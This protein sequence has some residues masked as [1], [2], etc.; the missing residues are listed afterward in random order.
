MNSQKISKEK[1]EDM[2]IYEFNIENKKIWKL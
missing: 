1:N 2:R